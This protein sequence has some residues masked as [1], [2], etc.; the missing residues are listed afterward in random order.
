[1]G[2][3][4]EIEVVYD[5]STADSGGA[6]FRRSDFAWNVIWSGADPTGVIDS[7]AAFQAAYDIVGPHDIY[8]PKGTYKVGPL[9]CS[10]SRVNVE[11][12]GPNATVLLFVP[13]AANQA[14]LTYQAANPAQVL[15]QCIAGKFSIRQTE[16]VLAKIG[17]D[18]YDV[19]GCYFYDIQVGPNDLWNGATG[20]VTRG[21]RISGRDLTQF[22]RVELA[23]TGGGSVL[24]MSNP[25]VA[26]GGLEDSDVFH[27]D[28]C[29]FMLGT[30]THYAIEYAD[31]AQPTDVLITG[32]DTIGGAGTF[33]LVN[34][35]S[36]NAAYGL[37]IFK[38]RCEGGSNGAFVHIEGGAS[39]NSLRGIHVFSC[40]VGG[41][42]LQKGFYLRDCSTVTLETNVTLMSPGDAWIDCDDVVALRLRGNFLRGSS[43][44]TMGANMVCLFAV[45][46]AYD[47]T[48]PGSIDESWTSS[49]LNTNVGSGATMFIGGP[50]GTAGQSSGSNVYIMSG[51]LAN[52][53]QKT[54]PL[55]T[56]A[57]ATKMAWFDV[58]AVGA[59][60]YAQ[61]S[62]AV[63]SLAPGVPP[64]LLSTVAGTNLFGVG[65]LAGKFTVFDGGSG[66]ISISLFNQTG[67]SMDYTVAVRW[68]T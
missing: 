10:Q 6:V 19:S 51:T 68:R 15:Y 38:H 57:P 17:I 23:T 62:A 55:G 3:V 13:T 30:S 65:N 27:F 34:T 22:A 18:L 14:C 7:T 21:T 16:G 37:T 43:V 1:M 54:I 48:A 67:E 49:T 9:V 44:A 58:Q 52:A 41:G 42:T 66:M 25:N 50:I 20:G 5:P 56:G 45:E 63:T 2:A 12:A 36:V 40:T 53:T 47:S 35:L 31:G 11:G 32:G 26:V 24:V 61:G 39:F 33:K 4:A 64:D 29:H 8:W 59:T 46:R 28:D 60:K